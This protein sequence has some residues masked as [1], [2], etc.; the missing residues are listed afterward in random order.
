MRAGKAPLHRQVRRRT[1]LGHRLA[2][3]L[4]HW[5]PGLGLPATIGRRGGSAAPDAPLQRLGLPKHWIRAAR[6]S[7]AVV[8]RLRAR[9]LPQPAIPPAR[10]CL[11]EFVAALA[12]TAG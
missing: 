7:D 9:P 2:N 11:A 6:A 12:A 3:V 4:P 10:V 8:H 5:M 1:G